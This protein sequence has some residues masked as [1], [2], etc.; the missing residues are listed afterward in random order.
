MTSTLFHFTS[1]EA[2]TTLIEWGFFE[3]W[4]TNRIIFMHN[5]FKYRAGRRLP[6]ILGH[7]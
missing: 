1:E 3:L 2:C 4:D 7:D 5:S 6:M